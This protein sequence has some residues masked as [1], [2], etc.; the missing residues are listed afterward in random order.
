M[1]R[2]TIYTFFAAFI[3][4]VAV[5]VVDRLAFYKM[6]QF[7][8]QVDHTREVITTLEKLSH[9]F[10]SLQVYSQKY[11]SIGERNFYEAY[12]AESTEV[13]TDMEHLKSLVQDNP[14]QKRRVDSISA[15]ISSI[16]DTLYRYNIAE[17]IL[18]GKGEMLK[19]VFHVHGMIN[20]GVVRENELL[21]QRKEELNRS[22]NITRVFS[23]IFSIL[24]AVFIAA[25]FV[26]NISLRKKG[27]WLEGLLETI[28]NT[29]QDGI[30]YYQAVRNKHLGNIKEFKIVYANP[31]IKLLVSGNKNVAGK[32]RVPELDSF[33]KDTGLFR[34]FSSVIAS[35][36][37]LEMEILYEK[38]D[39]RKWLNIIL[40]KMED[41]ITAT[42]HDI[43]S[44]K[45]YQEELKQKIT[46]LERSNAEL[47]EYAY[48]ASHD[49]QEPL[50]KIK[51][52]ADILQS[53]AG[54][55]TT[56]Q[57]DSLGKIL[58][59]SQRMTTLITDLL[60]YSSLKSQ[61]KIDAVDLN[62]ILKTVLDDMDVLIDQKNAKIEQQ[63]LPIVEGISSQLGQLFYNLVHNA[64]K[65]S[66]AD[67]EPVISIRSRHLLAEEQQRFNIQSPG[68]WVVVVIEDNGVGFNPDYADNIFGMFKRLHT[69]Q[70][71]EGSGIGLALV[72][73]VIEN[74]NGYIYTNSGIN[75]GASFFVLL[76][77]KRPDDSVST[78]VF[79]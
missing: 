10:K 22:T 54:N 66:A 34:Q 49:L 12:A 61:H 78:P 15:S 41:G 18:M 69:R 47:E 36:N 77:L 19:D 72:R 58:K 67:R 37:P 79:F 4:L 30:V 64:L 63:T 21:N 33:I 24:A 31:A 1:N 17:L 68:E 16:Y 71:Y 5:I 35:G 38:N 52:H 8:L 57:Q 70:Q 27:D 45:D 14:E 43:T 76:P 56:R 20:R 39:N 29:S 25:T 65:F 73:K 2:K 62:D 75:K 55:L 11:S 3:L 32:A 51:L 48:A 13:K 40:A 59:A 6:Q 60:T 74:H 46:E 9:H 44:L 42:F 28:L 7:T 50:R 53:G 26:S 23:L